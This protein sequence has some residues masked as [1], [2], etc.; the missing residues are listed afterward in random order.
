MFGVLAKTLSISCHYPS[1][2]SGKA[3]GVPCIMTNNNIKILSKRHCL[4]RI[5]IW[6]AD[7]C[8]IIQKGVPDKIILIMQDSQHL[9]IVTGII[10][11]IRLE[12]TRTK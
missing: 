9:L 11:L 1:K 5:S 2:T 7:N 10:T 8:P 6:L 12:I 3:P 4:G